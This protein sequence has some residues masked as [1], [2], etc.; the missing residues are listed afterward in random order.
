ML[1]KKTH[2]RLTKKVRCALTKFTRE[3]VLTEQGSTH[4]DGKEI[5]RAKHSL[6]RSEVLQ[7]SAKFISE[8]SSTLIKHFASG[9]EVNPD[10]IEPVLQEVGS[11]SLEARIFRLATLTWSVPVSEGYG[12]RMR[13][14]IWDA[15][16]DRLIGILAIGDP[17]FNLKVRDNLIG[18]DVEARKQRLIGVMDAFVLGALPPY[19]RLL[20]G[21][22]VSCLVRSKEVKDAFRRRYAKATSIITQ[23]DK[24]PKLVLVTTSSSLGRSSVYNRLRLGGED[25]F[26]RIG[27]TAGY[28]HFHIPPD[29]FADMR[30]LLSNAG[31]S[32]ADGNRFGNGPNWKFRAI[33]AALEMVGFD[34]DFL[35]HGIKREVFQCKLASNAFEVL[36]GEQK[37]PN[38]SNL[39]SV[40]EIGQMALDRWILPRAKSQ[41]DFQ[42][43]VKED[44]L[45]SLT[46]GV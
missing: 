25:Y 43:W 23:E 28:G 15:Y 21:K 30:Q 8:H 27:Y 12:R 38:Y 5:V 39:L 36:R 4:L 13:F 26:S 24:N 41:P 20:G 18:W 3:H 29:L 33:R 9:H 32:Y 1:D 42:N 34:R 6:Q 16:N 11:S 46:S 2:A 40:A 31:H 44:L 22:L 45:A 14:L 7:K 35:H 19:N 10:R 37:R 17:V